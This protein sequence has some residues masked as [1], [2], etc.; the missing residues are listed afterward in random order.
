MMISP[1]VAL[2]SISNEAFNTYAYI[3]FLRKDPIQRFSLKELRIALGIKV[4]DIRIERR[5][6][7]CLYHHLKELQKHQFIKFSYYEDEL[8]IHFNQF[9]DEISFPDKPLINNNVSPTEKR[10]LIALF[11]VDSSKNK[12][13][14]FEVCRVQ[15]RAGQ[16]ALS[17]LI[18]KN[19]LRFYS[20]K[21]LTRYFRHLW[22]DKKDLPSHIDELVRA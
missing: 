11:L 9:V 14:L 22:K 15:F 5:N 19:V 12:D 21:E 6:R 1:I 17:G 3:Q 20:P 10:M 18:E 13:K 4:K 2:S 7:D 16:R 8:T